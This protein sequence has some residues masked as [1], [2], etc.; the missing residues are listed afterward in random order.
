MS[1][2]RTVLP[3]VVS[4]TLLAVAA[5]GGATDTGLGE[6]PSASSTSSGGSSSGTSGSSSGASSSSGTGPEFATPTVCTSKTTWTRGDRGSPSMH[7][8]VA[9]IA[10]HATEKDA[11]AFTIAGTVY[12]SAHEP[13]DCSGVSGGAQV[14]VTDAA[15]KTLTLPVN[16]AGNFYSTS[17][18]TT[19]FRAKVVA[20]GKERAMAATQTVG[21][22]NSCH[23]EAGTSSAPGR[24]LTP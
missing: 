23:T 21:D 2:L 14:I 11:P 13:D 3:I 1:E 20:N 18:I 16:S 19:P 9:C 22:C 17:S 5:C 8:G 6:P 7:P 4:A 15:G 12:P 24:I 10:C